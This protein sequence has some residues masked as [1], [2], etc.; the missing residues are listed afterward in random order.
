MR[1]RL[2]PAGAAAA[3]VASTAMIAQQVAGKAT[4]DALFLSSFGVSALPAMMGISALGSLLAVLWLARMMVRHTP[5][6]VVPVGFGA[7]AAT[8]LA[9][10]GLSFGAPRAAAIVLYLYTSIFGAAMIS[11]FWSLINEAYD[12]HTNRT[13]AT[14]IATGGTLGGVLG[15]LAAWGLSAVIPVP[16]MLPALAGASLLS[17]WGSLGVPRREPTP[18]VVD[19]GPP[20][21]I[22]GSPKDSLA[23][24]TFAPAGAASVALPSC[25]SWLRS[26]RWAP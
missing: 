24:V 10:W 21:D 8:L 26:C 16:T 11:A 3:V 15:G 13:A 19:R 1:G 4:R 14:A 2:L 17:M 5:A 6:R 7:S 25:G 23:Q 20:Q 22:A 12:P 18:P 9:T